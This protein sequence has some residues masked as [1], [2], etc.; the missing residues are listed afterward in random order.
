M[1]L[2]RFVP[3]AH[4]DIITHSPSGKW[5]G[6]S[7]IYLEPPRLLQNHPEAQGCIPAGCRW[8]HQERGRLC[9]VGVRG[10]DWASSSKRNRRKWRP[11][12]PQAVPGEH[13]GRKGEGPVGWEQP[14]EGIRSDRYKCLVHWADMWEVRCTRLLTTGRAGEDAGK[15]ASRISSQGC[16]GVCRALLALIIIRPFF[17]LAQARPEGIQVAMGRTGHPAP[18]PRPLL[19]HFLWNLYRPETRE[20][21]CCTGHQYYLG[22]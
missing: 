15:T 20:Q 9:R 16:T 1:L 6:G 14:C 12:S 3:E 10:W 11:L 8:G 21:I 5:V 7:R 4:Q 22:A 18:S 13:S 17:N 2:L 19:G